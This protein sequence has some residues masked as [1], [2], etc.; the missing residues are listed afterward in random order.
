[1]YKTLTAQKLHYFARPQERV[2]RQQLDVRAAWKGSELRQRDDW[3]ETLADADIAEIERAIGLAHQTGKP[4]GEMTSG[5]FPLPTL[6][7]KIACWRIVPGFA[8]ASAA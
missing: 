8:A 6:S 1:M 7:K 3:C 4:I 2:L 5:D